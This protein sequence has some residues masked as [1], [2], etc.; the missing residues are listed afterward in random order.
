LDPPAAARAVGRAELEPGRGWLAPERRVD[1]G[2][3]LTRGK[4]A[5][6][7][8]QIVSDGRAV[9]AEQD[10]SGAVDPLDVIFAIDGHE[11]DGQS[12]QDALGPVA[13]RGPRL[14]PARGRMCLGPWAAIGPGPAGHD[15]GR[16]AD[17]C[18]W[19]EHALALPP[20]DLEPGMLEQEVFR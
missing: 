6:H 5:C 19:D 11:S 12:E 10:T 7:V 16:V 2:T 15:R 18:G 1:D 14:L 9:D 3:E 8:H 13:M 20:I 17:A 4:G